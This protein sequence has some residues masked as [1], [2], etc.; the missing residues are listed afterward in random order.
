MGGLRPALEHRT[1]KQKAP[2]G[3][4]AKTLSNALNNKPPNPY[5]SC[6][7]ESITD[8]GR[9]L[10]SCD[11]RRVQASSDPSRLRPREVEHYDLAWPTARDVDLVAIH[12]DFR[13]TTLQLKAY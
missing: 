7:L 2:R 12:K 10:C 3:G 5:S 8:L 6:R 11:S 13:D 9:A 4:H 1:E